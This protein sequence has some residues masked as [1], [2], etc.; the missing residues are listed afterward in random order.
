MILSYES[1]QLQNTIKYV[2]YSQK[3]KEDELDKGV[4]AEALRYLNSS[5]LINET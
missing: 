5:R 1:R 4:K 2:A 3:E